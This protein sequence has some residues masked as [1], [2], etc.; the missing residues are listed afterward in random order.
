LL[1]KR[2]TTLP[3]PQ[4][5][6]SSLATVQEKVQ[7]VSTEKSQTKDFTESEWKNVPAKQGLSWENVKNQEFVVLIVDRHGRM[8][9]HS[10]DLEE[11]YLE[12]PTELI[13]EITEKP[14]KEEDCTRTERYLWTIECVDR[15]LSKEEVVSI[16]AIPVI[17][18]ISVACIGALIIGASQH[19]HHN[20]HDHHI[21]LPVINVQKSSWDTYDTNPL[22]L[23]N[24][25]QLA[26]S[27]SE[28][29]ERRERIKREKKKARK[30][31]AI[32]KRRTYATATILESPVWRDWFFHHITSI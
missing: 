20:L 15:N 6:S 18:A 30:R 23:M 1:Q 5:P 13:R 4:K 31:E 8:L 19:H 7:P 3:L 29:E 12:D 26:E 22:I 16:V 28:E 25:S 32:L 2:S 10:P 21:T 14:L 9:T 27:S 11:P 24:F 17:L